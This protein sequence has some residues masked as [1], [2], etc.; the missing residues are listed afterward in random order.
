MNKLNTLILA[1]M[2]CAGFPASVIATETT[3]VV[4][5]TAWDSDSRGVASIAGLS[6]VQGTKKATRRGSRISVDGRP[7]VYAISGPG[8]TFSLTFT[9]DQPSFR[10]IAEGDRFPR[11]ITQP[12]AVPEDGGELDVGRVDSPRAEGPEHTWPLPMAATALGY[13]S[14]QEMLADNKAVIRLLTLGSGAD[15]APTWAYPMKL[16]FPGSGSTPAKSEPTTTSP[17]L[18]RVSQTEYVLPFDM[19]TQDTYFLPLDESTGAWIII[20]SFAAGEDPDKAVI[21]EL[22]DMVTDELLDPPRPWKFSPKKI[23]VRNGYA[24]EVRYQ[25]DLEQ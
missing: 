19:N 11:A 9:T 8:G 16:S 17:F 10:L 3:L 6:V 20:V 25:P 12:I 5:G 13:E 23:L 21:L 14:S 24:T 7:E 15:G 22:E 18:M 4:T 2:L 1:T